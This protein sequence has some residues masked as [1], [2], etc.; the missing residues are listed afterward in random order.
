MDEVCL[1]CTE[2]LNQQNKPTCT[3][4]RGLKSI[5]TKSIEYDDEL[6]KKLP[7]ISSINVH[8]ECRKK[9]PVQDQIK[10]NRV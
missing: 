9:T 5:F 6:H 10:G 2:S 4:S 8:V 7:N 3:V 1:F